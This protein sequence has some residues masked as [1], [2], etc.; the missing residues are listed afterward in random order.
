LDGTLNVLAIGASGF[1]GSHLVD[2]L[3]GRGYYGLGVDNMST[4]I[5]RSLEDAKSHDSFH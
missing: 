5:S 4:G 2:E 3:L 1:I